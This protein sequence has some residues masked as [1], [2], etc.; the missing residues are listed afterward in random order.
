[1]LSVFPGVA[2]WGEGGEPKPSLF[3][4]EAHSITDPKCDYKYPIPKELLLAVR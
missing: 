1:M 3:V 4:V 2:A